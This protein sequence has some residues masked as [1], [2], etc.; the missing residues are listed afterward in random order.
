[1][2][3]SGHYAFVAMCEEEPDTLVGV[4]RECPLVVGLGQG[5]QFI[6][7]SIAAFLAHTREV[8]VLRDGEIV[9]LG[10]R[11]VTVFDVDGLPHRPA[12]TRIDWDEDRMEKDG[13]ETFMLKEIHEQGTA[14]ADTLSSARADLAAG[15]NP[16]L[17]DALR[18]ESVGSSSLRAEPPITPVWP[19]SWRSSGGL[20]FLSRST[21]RRS[22]GIAIRS[23]VLTRSFS[24]SRSRA[25]P[26]IRSR[27]CGSHGHAA[28]P[29]SP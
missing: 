21:S 20:E 5:E 24:G 1:M 18:A 19:G 6:A 12:F 7:S 9:V 16:A 8:V 22:F 28:Q 29:W 23:W 3:L 11:D 13:F 26:P 25:K 17:T 14:A 2:E 15:S 4:R 10:A 27:R